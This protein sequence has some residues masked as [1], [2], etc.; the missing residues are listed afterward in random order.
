MKRLLIVLALIGSPALAQDYRPLTTFHGSTSNG[1]YIQG[2]TSSAGTYVQV[3]PPVT[4]SPSTYYPAYPGVAA[5]AP[6]VP[7]NY[8][9]YGY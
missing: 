2:Q 6:C 9:V 3:T 4:L 8:N 5:P 7:T 1:G